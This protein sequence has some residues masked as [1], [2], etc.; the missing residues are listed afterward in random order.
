MKGYSGQDLVFCNSV[1]QAYSQ[2]TSSTSARSTVHSAV[3]MSD[4]KPVSLPSHLWSALEQMASEMGVGRDQLIAQSVFTLA[5]LNGYLL[6]G[7]VHVASG[8]PPRLEASPAPAAAPKSA[9]SGLRNQS[10]RRA[11][12]VHEEPPPD[13]FAEEPDEEEDE[14]PAGSLSDELPAASQEEDLPSE[15]DLPADE[16]EFPPEDEESELVAAPPQRGGKL[17]L[18]VTFNG[19]EAYRMTGDAMTIGRGKTC[20]LV[21]ESNRVSREHARISREGAD[22]VYEDLNSSNGSFFGPNKDKVT[23]RKLK[24]GDEL[25][26]GTEKVKFTMRR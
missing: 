18:V 12:P 20:E 21:I 17:N 8:G 19:K 23:R 2:K 14:A 16:E 26:L 1:Q 7:K 25:T 13:D 3:T 22:F 9:A 24:D 4:S 11:E 5:R 15:D 10:A 6:P